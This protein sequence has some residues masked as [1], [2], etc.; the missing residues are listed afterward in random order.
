MSFL[1]SIGFIESGEQE[2]A[3]LATAPEGSLNHYL[4]TLPVTINE[5]PKDLLV[6]L[7]RRQPHTDRAYRVVVVPIEFREDTLPE[8]VEEEPLP[9]KLHPGSWLC[10]VVFSEHPDYP[11]GGFR[12]SVPGAQ[13]ARGRKVD[14]AKA[15]ASLPYVSGDA[16]HAPEPQCGS[17]GASPV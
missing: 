8:G 5:W 17:C 11:A 10:A 1:R 3:R 16:P 12:I 4:S 9:R 7:P 15:L 2:R 14:L 13:I 6:E